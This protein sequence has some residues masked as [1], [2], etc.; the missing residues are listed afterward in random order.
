MKQLLLLGLLL[1][2]VPQAY[3]ESPAVV[4]CQSNEDCSKGSFCYWSIGLCGKKVDV[5]SSSEKGI[6]RPVPEIC[7]R[8]Y[9]PV[10]GCDAKTYPTTCSAYSSRQSV[11]AEGK[12]EA[13]K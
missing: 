2:I 1:L 11:A 4:V 13:S 6:C 9:R 3:A 12:C 10:C 5:E 7:T 8:E